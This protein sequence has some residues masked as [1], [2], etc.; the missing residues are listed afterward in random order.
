MEQGLVGGRAGDRPRL[1]PRDR[2]PRC[3][4]QTF[5]HH[6]ETR[7]R[8]LLPF[9]GGLLQ[10]LP[11]LPHHGAAARRGACAACGPLTVGAIRGLLAAA[12][13]GHPHCVG[14]ASR[15]ATLPSQG[16]GRCIR[17]SFPPDAHQRADFVSRLASGVS[18][19]A[20]GMARLRPRAAAKTGA[21]RAAAVDV[22]AGECPVAGAGLLLRQVL[23]LRGVGAPG[24]PPNQ[25]CSGH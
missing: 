3:G 14:G 2:L 23:C 15:S 6:S 20:L 25:A 12:L 13:P 4:G 11:R 10:R 19:R 8:Q 1:G 16:D 24:R 9:L 22:A 17:A 21:W 5:A 7:L 18:L